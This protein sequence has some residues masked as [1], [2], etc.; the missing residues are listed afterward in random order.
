MATGFPVRSAKCESYI[1]DVP[2]VSPLR[3]EERFPEKSDGEVSPL[4]M[5]ARFP[6]LARPDNALH[7]ARSG[8]VGSYRYR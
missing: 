1:S 2:D 5:D 3:S 6:R 4:S 8:T 7:P